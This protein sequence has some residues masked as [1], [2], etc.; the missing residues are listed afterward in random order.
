M[1]LSSAAVDR[2][3]AI[4]AQAAAEQ[5]AAAEKLAAIERTTAA[6]TVAAAHDMADAAKQRASKL[7]SITAS[8][9]R[10]FGLQDNYTPF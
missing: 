7:S 8:L 6:Y 2:V 4:E 10:P 5:V 9:Q 3:A 1:L